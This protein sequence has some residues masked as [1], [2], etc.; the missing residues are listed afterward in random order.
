[1][2]AAGH[3]SALRGT[4][5][6]LP[7]RR[8]R[9]RPALAA[10][11][12]ALGPAAP[13]RLR[14]RHHLHGAGRVRLAALDGDARAVRARPG[15][16]RARRGAARDGGPA[17][18][19]PPERRHPLGGG[20]GHQPAG[21]PARVH[22]R[23]HL[24][25]A[26]APRQ[27]GRAGHR[28][29]A[30]HRRPARRARALPRHRP[31]DPARDPARRHDA[32]RARGADR[33]LAAAQRHRLPDRRARDAGDALRR[34][35]RRARLRGRVPARRAAGDARAG[36]PAAGAA[37]AQRGRRG[38]A[39]RARRRGRRADRRARDRRRLAVVGLRVMG[40]RHGLLA[41]DLVLLEPRLRPARL[42]ARRPR[43][44]A[45]EGQAARLL[46]GREPR[47]VRRRALEGVGVR[48]ARGHRPRAPG[49]ARRSASASP[50]AS[51]STSAT[52]A[53]AR[54]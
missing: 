13:A 30:R 37:A 5:P 27:L 46:E 42:A 21:D 33:V 44:A 43:D 14:A 35:G 11:A 12:A 52:C 54:S 31:V 23:R 48:H 18:R 28:H 10:R 38:R 34:A 9:R 39:A 25:R 20:G 50:S 15:V 36:L 49:P 3:I 24:R 4:A 6:A 19:R 29:P 26:A 17:A 8:A 7:Q 1:M 53:R 22:R 40:A 2:S 41:L 32:G 45:R 16:G 51:R 47:R